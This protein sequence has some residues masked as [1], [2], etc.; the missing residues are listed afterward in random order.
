MYSNE[1]DSSNVFLNTTFCFQDEDNI[2]YD[3]CISS[4]YTE[5]S[6]ECWRRKIRM[7]FNGYEAPSSNFHTNS[8][9]KDLFQSYIYSPLKNL[10]K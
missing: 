9:F 6:K 1:V 2:N 8:T 10:I 3:N 7:N 4:F 5:F